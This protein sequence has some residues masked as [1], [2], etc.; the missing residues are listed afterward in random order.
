MGSVTS[1][2]CRA[3]PIETHTHTNKPQR[4]TFKNSIFIESNTLPELKIQLISLLAVNQ[5]SI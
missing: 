3:Y 1:S 4:I 5:T 2:Q